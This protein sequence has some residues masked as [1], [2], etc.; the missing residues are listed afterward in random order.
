MNA[1]P[2]LLAFDGFLDISRYP[3]FRTAF[4][5]VPADRPVLVD[6]TASTGVDSTFLSELL[7]LR[8]RHAAGLAVLIPVQGTVREMFLLAGLGRRL[9]V[10]TDRAEAEA[11]LRG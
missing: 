7:M 9:D 6:L 2:H 1:L 8:R 5:D 10:F 4:V 11:S 3:D